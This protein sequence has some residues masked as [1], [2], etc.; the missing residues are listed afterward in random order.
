MIWQRIILMK[1]G[2]FGNNM[3]NKG[4]EYGPEPNLVIDTADWRRARFDR[5]FTF[6]GFIHVD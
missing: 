1:K 6:S 5:E 4:I 2:N 3:E